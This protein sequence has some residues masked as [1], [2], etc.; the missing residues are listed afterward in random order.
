MYYAVI[1]HNGGLR[2]QAKC[3]KHEP[4][5]SVFFI[6]LV[7]S[8]V[9]SVLSQCNTW[10]RLLHLLYDNYRF[11]ACK[12][13]ENTLSLFYTL[14]KHGF[15]TNQSTRRVLSTVYY[16]ARYRVIRLT[17]HFNTYEAN[18]RNRKHVLC[19]C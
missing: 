12:R 11:Y 1:K 16:K 8:N 14:I 17:L 6:S 2:T 9:W 18:L 4:Q 19:L 15:L 13:K 3:R 5:A 10:L 7:F